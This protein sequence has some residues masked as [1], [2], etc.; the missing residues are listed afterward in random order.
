MTFITIKTFTDPNEA[1][2]C[3]GR[4]E[5]EGI[6]CFLNNEASIGA[7]PLLQNAVGGYQL[8]CSENDAE[9]A[10]KILEEK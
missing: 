3:K 6:K 8:Q 2:I 7:N 1:N 5:S 10:L 9:K 4:L